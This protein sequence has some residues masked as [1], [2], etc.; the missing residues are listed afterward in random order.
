VKSIRDTLD[1]IGRI[2]RSIEKH[3]RVSI[4]LAGGYAV[5]AHG[6]ERTTADVDF[7]I[8]SD[9]IH[10]KH[11]S[12]FVKLLKKAI[13]KT[14]KIELMEGSKIPDDPFKHDVIFVKDKT[15]KYPKIDLI[16]T[17]YK[18]E[19]EGVRK[20]DYLEDL[21]FPVLPKPYLIAMKLKAGSY[22]D[23]FDVSELYG[24]LNKKE[25]QKTRE[26]ARLIHRDKRLA[27]LVLKPKKV[28]P[29]KEDR[30]LLIKIR[31]KH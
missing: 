28:E 16:I 20:P 29:E 27:D 18:W 4:A 24:L 6:V 19:L 8:Y 3:D 25:Q 10:E 23:D 17:K 15:G 14:F 12:A 31:P 26:L 5:I 21:P 11:V 9:I 2:I 7:C 1:L 13:P 30:S 22:K